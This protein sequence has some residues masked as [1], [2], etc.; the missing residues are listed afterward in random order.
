MIYYY[1]YMPLS[2]RRA[3]NRG[4]DTARWAR[5]EYGVQTPV[6]NM[7]SIVERIG[8]TL[9][10]LSIL[11]LCDLCPI[12]PYELV[13][14]DGQSFTIAYPVDAVS[15]KRDREAPLS[16]KETVYVA[17]ALGHLFLGMGYR[18]DWDRWDALETGAFSIPAGK[19]ESW[20]AVQAFT[21]SFLAPEDDLDW[22]LNAL[23]GQDGKVDLEK[24][25][26]AFGTSISWIQGRCQGL[27]RIR[28][29]LDP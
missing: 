24:L 9:E 16:P 11:E 3:I 5:S 10:P 1:T 17:R 23:M 19:G 20:Y 21:D 8:G 25:A 28:T 2:W 27:G 18:L 13:R 7:R 4:K 6:T 26:S 22:Y 12:H 14:K 15:R 29:M